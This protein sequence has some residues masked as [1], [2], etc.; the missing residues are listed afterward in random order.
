MLALRRLAAASALLPLAFG[1]CLSLPPV[2]KE[3][4]LDLDVSLVRVRDDAPGSPVVTMA[5]AD[6]ETRLV[7]VG[8]PISAMVAHLW[9]HLDVEQA[10]ELPAG[11]YDAT[12]E[13][14]SADEV[15]ARLA[16]AVADG[17]RVAI[18]EE[19]RTS[20]EHRLVAL[21]DTTLQPATKDGVAT[22]DFKFHKD[23]DRRTLQ[24]A[25]S[26]QSFVDLLP[27]MTPGIVVRDA[28][29]ADT[30]L[31][32]DGE[33]ASIDGLRALLQA[34]GF[35]LAPEAKSRAVL[36]VERADRAD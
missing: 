20:V 18:R 6:G 1:A 24:Y 23:G 7:A 9:P 8:A 13:G 30:L 35:D 36:R 28:T 5:S 2:G 11:R 12:V 4:V 33:F 10:A 32:V 19:A 26:T 34:K 27:S 31:T 22:Q 3:I 16:A 21:P 25:G 17:L 29:P 14:A 15:R